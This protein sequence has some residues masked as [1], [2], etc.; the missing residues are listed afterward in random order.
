[1][2]TI[3]RSI[4]ELVPD[5]LTIESNEFELMEAASRSDFETV[6]A[7]EN[8]DLVLSDFKIAGFEGLQVLNTIHQKDPE[9][10]VVI[11]TGTGSEEIAVEAMKQ[12]AADYVIKKFHHIQRLTPRAKYPGSDLLHSFITRADARTSTNSAVN[13]LSSSVQRHNILKMRQSG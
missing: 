5:A 9:I 3:T 13:A 2:S 11:V 6:L 7:Q 10:P 1:M 8:F 4:T 12:G